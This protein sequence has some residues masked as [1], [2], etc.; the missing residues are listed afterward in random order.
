MTRQERWGKETHK[1][2]FRS[3]FT[4]RR[5]KGYKFQDL[6]RRVVGL[7]N[8]LEL[9]RM[10]LDLLDL[11][12]VIRM[13]ESGLCF[14]RS[15]GKETEL[16]GYQKSELV[17]ESFIN[18]LDVEDRERVTDI[19]ADAT[20]NKRDVMCCV[21]R[22]VNRLSGRNTIMEISAKPIIENNEVVGFVGLS[23]DITERMQAEIER[24]TLI[25][26][27]I[28]DN[29][30]DTLTGAHSRSYLY[31]N[32]NKYCTIEETINHFRYCS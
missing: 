21:C 12:W 7:E 10:A 13:G 23:Q 17:G 16:L 4:E 15:R 6:E 25:K 20:R 28:H 1:L 8:D 9:S 27:L 29:A 11:A 32:W 22:A 2:P 14:D 3:Y 26:K 24:D 18:T 19:F 5:V 31:K 30:H